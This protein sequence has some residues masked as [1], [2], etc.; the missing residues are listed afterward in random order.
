MIVFPPRHTHTRTVWANPAGP[1][2]LRSRQHPK[3]FLWLRGLPLTTQANTLV[4]R[5]LQAAEAG[6]ESKARTKYILEHPEDLGMTE[7]GGN[8]A[9][10]RQLAEVRRLAQVTSA[11]SR[12]LHQCSY[13]GASSAK[14]AW[15]LGNFTGLA[16]LLH[17]GWPRFSKAGY[18]TGQLLPIHCGH[19]HAALI[20]IDPTA[21]AF[22]TNHRLLIQPGSAKRSHH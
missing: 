15:L 17:V 7:K 6:Y 10:I 1:R 13:S 21:G 16:K 4:E 5:G 19:G 2:P 3:G 11:V 22:T 8:L 12:A 9:S 18:Y 20:W 14:P